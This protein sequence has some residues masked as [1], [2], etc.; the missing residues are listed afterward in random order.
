MKFEI[1]GIQFSTEELR[2]LFIS[3]L[4]L[5]F[6]FSLVLYRNEIFS[7]GGSF[8]GNYTPGFF[9]N[10]LIVVGL[11]F[12]LHE[13]LG[14]K[15][16]AQR[17]GYWAEYRTWPTGLFLALIMAIFSRGSFVFA[18]PGAVVISAHT[19]FQHVDKEKMG[20]IAVAGS[21]VNIIL[22]LIFIGLS[23]IFTSELFALG[24][25]VNVWLALFNMIPIGMLDGA[26]VI[27]WDRRIWG[28]VLGIAIILLLTSGLILTTLAA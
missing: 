17:F 19:M 1:R 11:A 9:I 23:L 16:V 7:S 28:G 21:V 12:I 5:S 22:A 4:V 24:A 26:K 6:A 18:A 8:F 14:H 20:K 10:S 13:E 3:L 27:R 25:Q 15:L 2:Q